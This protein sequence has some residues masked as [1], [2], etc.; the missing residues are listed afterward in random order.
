M[1]MLRRILTIAALAAAAALASTPAAAQSSQQLQDTGDAFYYR[2]TGG[3]P[4]G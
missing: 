1:S 4:P 2:G 3:V